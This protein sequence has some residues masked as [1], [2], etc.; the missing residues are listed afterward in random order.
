MNLRFLG[1][2]REVTGSET[3]PTSNCRPS[4]PASPLASRQEII[5]SRFS[6][7]YFPFRQAA[8]LCTGC[9]GGRP[10]HVQ[11]RKKRTI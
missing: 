3:A 9:L 11:H 4:Q 2:A 5:A 6:E 8:S 7:R 10:A 1:V